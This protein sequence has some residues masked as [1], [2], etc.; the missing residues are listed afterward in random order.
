MFVTWYHCVFDNKDV[1]MKNLRF[2]QNSTKDYKI[3]IL[4]CDKYIDIVI[5]K[6]TAILISKK[7]DFL[8]EIDQN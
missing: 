6:K 4:K 2:F 7:K 3:E 8:L 5:K 1:Q